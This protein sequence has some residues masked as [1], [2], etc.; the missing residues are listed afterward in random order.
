MITAI[1]AQVMAGLNGEVCRI[2]PSPKYAHAARPDGIKMDG[3]ARHQMIQRQLYA[4]TLRN[5]RAQGSI[6]DADA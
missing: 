3:Q 1:R 5:T 2:A 6:A 4:G